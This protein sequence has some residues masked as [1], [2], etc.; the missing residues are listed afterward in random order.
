MLRKVVGEDK[1]EHHLRREGY[2]FIVGVDEAGRGPL[3][4][5]VVVCAISLPFDHNISGITDSKNIS[6]KERERLAAEIKK[7]ARVFSI[8]RIGNKIIDKIN[9]RRATLLAMRRAVLNL[10]QKVNV[11]PDVILVDGKDSIDLPIECR[12][13]VKGDLI[14]ENIGAASILAKVYRDNLMKKLDRK[15]PQYGFALHKG[16]GTSDHYEAIKRYG[17]CEIHRRSF[18]LFR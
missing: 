16:Y 11:R 9:I 12:A 4:G 3:A 10:L 1:I 7:R 13:I 2:R 14:S 6:E 5:P 17:L 15:Y 8:C 18:R